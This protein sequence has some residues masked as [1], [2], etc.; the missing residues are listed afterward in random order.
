[1][2]CCHGDTAGVDS[3]GD[4]SGGRWGLSGVILVL[5]TCVDLSVPSCVLTDV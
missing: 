3:D 5:A 1:M 4:A 2:R